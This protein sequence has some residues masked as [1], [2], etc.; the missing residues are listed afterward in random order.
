LFDSLQC[1]QASDSPHFKHP[2]KLG[3]EQKQ[4]GKAYSGHQSIKNL[5]SVTEFIGF[6]PNFDFMYI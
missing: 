2:L 3:N 1:L 6:L 4:G 5:L